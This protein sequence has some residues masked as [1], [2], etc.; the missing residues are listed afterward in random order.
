MLEIMIGN[1]TI[2]G[3]CIRRTEADR[4]T[5]AKFSYEGIR[6]PHTAMDLYGYIELFFQHRFK[7][8]LQRGIVRAFRFVSNP[9]R[10]RHDNDAIHRPW[11]VREELLMDFSTQ[12]DY[13]GVRVGEPKRLRCGQG[14]DEIAKPIGPENGDLSHR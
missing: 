2:E 13:L 4:H 11:S 3:D 1:P 7:K 9:L 10:R 12:P 5:G 8:A 6:K 14:K